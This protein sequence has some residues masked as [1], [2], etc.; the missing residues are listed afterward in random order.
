MTHPLFL[1]SLANKKVANASVRALISFYYFLFVPNVNQLSLLFIPIIT[2]FLNGFDFSNKWFH[3][4]VCSSH[5]SLTQI[6]Q[7]KIFSDIKLLGDN[8]VPAKKSA[9]FDLLSERAPFKHF[10][11]AVLNKS[12]I[13]CWFALFFFG[14]AKTSPLWVFLRQTSQPVSSQAGQSNFKN[15]KLKILILF[16]FVTIIVFR[17]EYGKE[18]RLARS[19]VERASVYL[20]ESLAR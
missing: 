11:S 17:A 12:V 4:K 13:V 15:H 5:V 10:S 3:N 8:S 1:F 2:S 19:L 16:L 6:F 18:L 20:S 7:Q 9:F 14:T